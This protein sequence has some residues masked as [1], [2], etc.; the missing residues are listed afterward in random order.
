QHKSGAR[1]SGKQQLSGGNVTAEVAILTRTCVALAADSALTVRDERGYKT[2][3]KLLAL[4]KAQP[5]ATMIFGNADYISVPW[6]TVIKTFR[7][8]NTKKWDTV[9][10]AAGDLYEY[11]FA[12]KFQNLW[13]EVDFAEMFGQS[14]AEE[15][16]A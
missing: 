8:Q 6:E 12:D 3:H 5:I 9:E 4:S 10:D 7:A 13:D 2:A 16:L 14:Y 1:S 11:L 15:V